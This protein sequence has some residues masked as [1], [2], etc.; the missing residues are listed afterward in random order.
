LLD[1]IFAH[2]SIIAG[3]WQARDSKDVKTT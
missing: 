1:G 3:G 2:T